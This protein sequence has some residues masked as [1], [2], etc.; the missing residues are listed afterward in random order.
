MTTMAVTLGT[1]R[2][3]FYRVLYIQVLIAIVLGGLL[4]W[5]YPAIGTNPW[6]AALGTGFVKLV[7]M[8]VT[9]IIFCTVVSGISHLKDSRQVGRIGLKTLVY[10]EVVS[11]IAL[12]VGLVVGNLVQPGAGF[13]GTVPNASAVANFVHQAEHQTAV[14]FVLNIIP[15][16]VIGAFVKNDVLQ[17]IL[18]SI[19]FGFGL[20][21]AGER[22][23][24]ARDFVD[25]AAR[26]IYGVIAIVMKA[27]PFASFG[28]MAFTIGKFGP[29][30]I[31]NLFGMLMTFYLSVA[32]FVFVVLGLV[33]YW[34]GFSIL[35]FI[36][37]I[38]DE[39]L[40]TL[41]TGS[42]ESVLPQLMDKLENLGCSKSVVG[43]VVPAGYS[44]NND[45]GNIYQTLATIFVAQL[46]GFDLTWTQQLGIV[47]VAM[48]TSKGT[49]GVAGAGFITLAAT[50]SVFDPKLV[51][52]M[53]VLLGIDKFMS[54]CRAVT[55]IVG[56]GVAAI[57]VSRWEGEVDRNKLNEQL[58]RSQQRTLGVAF[59]PSTP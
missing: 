32:F 29:Q 6:I 57:I 55:N 28:A 14:G 54:E 2:K 56:N 4:G 48:L 5:L 42:S 43:L 30:V 44:F 53:A 19:L 38:K 17:V 45:G 37:Y 11:T 52:G 15:D 13:A 12:I 24:L 9:P 41:G 7:K 59:D 50:L 21:M 20:Q 51:P 49:A 16:S 10:F 31:S 33:A 39:L 8:V 46:M 34:A 58:G 40:I 1:S 35:K 47:L 25:S 26:G 36:A 22:G 27:A 23:R 3:P 18:F